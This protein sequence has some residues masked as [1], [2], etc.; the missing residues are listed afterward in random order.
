MVERGYVR[1]RLPTS[2]CEF[3]KMEPSWLFRRKYYSLYTVAI[4][5]KA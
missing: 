3:S 1:K 5:E 2:R 4:Q